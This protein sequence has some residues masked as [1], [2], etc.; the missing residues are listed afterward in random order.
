MKTLIFLARFA[1][2][3]IALAVSGTHDAQ[4]TTTTTIALTTARVQVVNFVQALAGLAAV[5]LL[6]VSV[7]EFVGHKN[8][9]KAAF[10]LVGVLIS[11][12]IS[13][14]AGQ[15]A[16]DFGLVGAVL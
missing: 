8:V 13:I 4:A 15:V 3:V 2:F 11:S 10:E 5:G 7:W 6:G 1:P 12:L 14:N 16:Q 9:G